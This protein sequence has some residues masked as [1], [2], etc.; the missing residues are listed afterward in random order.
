MH[1][2]SNFRVRIPET[3]VASATRNFEIE[4]RNVILVEIHACDNWVTTKAQ[5]V[6]GVTQVLL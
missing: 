1:S 6:E 2:G 3:D 5:I 4:S